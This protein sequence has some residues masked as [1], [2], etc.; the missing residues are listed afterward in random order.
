[1]SVLV[2]RDTFYVARPTRE[3]DAHGWADGEPEVGVGTVTGTMQAASTVG[4]GTFA[5]R[6]GNG[7]HDPFVQTTA[8]GYFDPG[9]DLYP[10]DVLT[11]PQGPWRIV[12]VQSSRDP[13][14]S[15]NLDCLVVEAVQ[16]IDRG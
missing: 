14:D 8:V 4:D 5:D 13:R 10:G 3:L 1:M 9:A 6:G 16:V 11:G 12:T 2:R 15:G 7:P